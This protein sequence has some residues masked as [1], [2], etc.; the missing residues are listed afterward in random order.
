MRTLV[1]PL[2]LVLVAA[3]ALAHKERP[4][5]SPVRSGSVPD[6]NRVNSRSVVVCKASSKPTRAEHRDILNRLRTAT[7][8]ELAQAQA[9]DAAW[10]RN[11]RLFKKCRYEHIQEAVNAASDDTDI[12]VLPGVYREEPSRAA[13]T[14]SGGDLSDGSYSYEYQAAN[15]NDQNLIGIMGKKNITL[16]GTGLTP[17][18]VLIDN[19]FTKDVGVRCDRCEGFIVRNL[20]QQDANEHGIY[21]VDSDGYIFD[22]A[23]GRYNKEYSLFSFAS[24]HGLYT[25]C[26]AMGGGDSGLYIGGQPDTHA[27][28]RFA[29]EVRNTKMYHSALGFSG[30]QGSSIWMHDNDVFDNAIGLSFDSENDHPNFPE[31]WSLI[32]NNRLHD[33]NFDIYA[34]T[35]DV[36]ARGP[37]YDF[38]RYPVG[39][40][41]WIIGGDDNIIRNNIIWNNIRFGFIL[42]RNPQEAPLPSEVQRN[43][44]YGN[45]IG[46]DPDGNAAPNL[47]AFPP[48]SCTPGTCYARGGS[49]FFWD[50]TGNDN[51]WGAQDPASG[52]VKTDP[53][54]IPGPCPMMNLGGTGSPAKLLLLLNCSL[55]T[56]V[57]PPVTNDTTYPCPW[58]HTNDAPYRNGDEQQCGNGTIDRGEDCDQYGSSTLVPAETC[59]SLGHGPGT[60]A[61]T[62]TPA[63]CTWDTSGCTAKSCSEYG[64]SMVRLRRVAAPATDDEL[65]FRGMELPGATFD[66]LTEDVS[67]VF[68]DDDGLVASALVPASSAGWTAAS[69]SYRYDDGV[70]AI[71][72]QASPSFATSFRA[73]VRLRSGVGAGADAR[74]G[75]AVLRVGDDCWSDT[76]PCAPRG[77]NVV[78]RGRSRP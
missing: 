3:P 53:D 77:P 43:Q 33:N 47:T 56:S 70:V 20:T 71:T 4:I 7:G 21:V 28:G 35:S 50:Q 18:D 74:T 39:T 24:D 42:A 17:A 78:C 49:D 6:L 64:A 14:T 76:T 58:G 45:K 66:P 69:G 13:P 29:A 61:C 65:N 23:I 63:A 38:F 19:G 44:V 12:L 72:L 62:T 52:T 51:C 9:E 16:E 31:R 2:A 75:T 68:R 57:N 25:D 30:T 8:D 11:S 27:F 37:A 10:H 41:M 32:E 40:A 34:P 5:D 48:T 46:V 55:D 67:F 59:D 1:V 73:D 22:R 54:P 15:P 26:E 60:L 36:P